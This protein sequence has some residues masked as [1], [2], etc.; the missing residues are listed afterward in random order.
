MTTLIACLKS[1]PQDLQ[2]INLAAVSNQRATVAEHLLR[3]VRDEDG[4]E[5]RKE[6]AFGR[7]SSAVGIVGGP[8]I[9][10]EI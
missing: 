1:L 4:Y 9:Y 6:R 10:R 8:T 2:M 7:D 5:V 3:V